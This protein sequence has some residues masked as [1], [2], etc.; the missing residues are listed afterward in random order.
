MTMNDRQ[1]TLLR[2]I[3]EDYIRSAAPLGSEYLAQRYPGLGV[4]SATVRNEMAELTEDGYLEQPYTSA[5]RIPTEKAYRLFVN[6]ILEEAYRASQRRLREYAQA[7]ESAR[8]ARERWEKS[9]AAFFASTSKTL[10]VCYNPARGIY[11]EGLREFLHE[12]EFQGR[13]QLLEAILFSES[14]DENFFER[15]ERDMRRGTTVKVFIGSENPANIR[16]RSHYSVVVSSLTNPQG[17]E[18]YI[19]FAGPLRMRY[20]KLIGLAQAVSRGFE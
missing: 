16:G 3:V 7:L 10:S 14:L 8:E 6:D 11:K 19:A 13:E 5:G 20:R 1:A 4:S 9:L 17:E 15:V 2:Y 12:P 18:E